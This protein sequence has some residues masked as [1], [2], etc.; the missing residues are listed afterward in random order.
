MHILNPVINNDYQPDGNVCIYINRGGFPHEAD[1]SSLDFKERDGSIRA[2]DSGTW[3]VSW[4]ALQIRPGAPG[5][6]EVTGDGN[7]VATHSNGSVYWSTDTAGEGSSFLKLEDSGSLCL[8]TQEGRITWCSG[9]YPTDPPT[10]TGD[11]IV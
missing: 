9:A 11:H 3:I 7:F 5:Y 10:L 2:D 4:C 8:H 6:L 1:I